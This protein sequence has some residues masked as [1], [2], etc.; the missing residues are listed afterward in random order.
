MEDY[1]MNLSTTPLDNLSNISEIYKQVT[2]AFPKEKILY[3]EQE[4]GIYNPVL[5]IL[6]I[7]CNAKNK[8]PASF[9]EF[10]EKGYV[11]GSPTSSGKSTVLLN[12]ILPKIRDQVSVVI[13][14]AP[15]TDL[16][17]SMVSEAKDI[18]SL[19]KHYCPM[20]LNSS[21]I[22]TYIEMFDSLSKDAP[23]PVFFASQ[24]FLSLPKNQPLIEEFAKKCAA[25]DE[26]KVV[27]LF[28]DE[29]HK[30][31]GT[32]GADWTK[33]NYGYW[34][35]VFTA[36]AFNAVSSFRKH[37][38][39]VS[40]GFSATPTAEQKLGDNFIQIAN[41]KRDPKLSPA[42]EF[43]IKPYRSSLNKLV[44]IKSVKECVDY[45]MPYIKTYLTNCNEFIKAGIDVPK[46]LWK[47]P[48]KQKN[49]PFYLIQEVEKELRKRVSLLLK[50]DN[51]YI[52]RNDENESVI[53]GKKIDKKQFVPFIN[54][55]EKHPVIIL[56]VESLVVGTNI[57][58]ITHLIDWTASTQQE[59]IMAK[60]Q[61]VGRAMRTG[62]PRYDE[63]MLELDSKDISKQHKLE[64]IDLIRKRLTK[65]IHLADVPI[66][67]MVREDIMQNTFRSFG[68]YEYLVNL[69]EEIETKELSN[70]RFNRKIICDSCG[71]SCLISSH[72][73]YVR[74]TGKKVTMRS[75]MQ[76][77]SW[78]TQ[79]NTL[80]KDGDENNLDP[81]NIEMFCHNAYNMRES[82]NH[83]PQKTF[84]M[85]R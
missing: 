61:L 59:V 25:F 31:A 48:R 21:N 63:M 47:L 5:N 32:S 74:E 44:D 76:N 10:I 8:S 37:A 28:I 82:L 72:Q 40:F 20:E 79:L 12:H 60:D 73:Q 68:L 62:M 66:S 85:N 1:I 46:L 75:F 80:F 24:Q 34:F 65:F 22:R 36:A 26:S 7:A 15:A 77:D 64:I 30:G 29:T 17:F 33:D 4:T 6:T 55:I 41:T 14:C 67:N 69:L 53:N 83:I 50:S 84:D 39:A 3:P 57:P 51:F 43:I 45:S 81:K 19:K 58:S 27:A 49:L 42:T 16:V 23:T 70:N 71:E 11:I 52:V 13:T 38:N 9:K 2:T 18:T 56:V 54:K 35:K 78:I